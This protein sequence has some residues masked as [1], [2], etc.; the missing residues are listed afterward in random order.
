M[1][2]N[3]VFI[4]LLS[5]FSFFVYAEK[6]K[7]G[8]TKNQQSVELYFFWSHRCPHCLEA[9]PFIENLA[10]HYS[11]L[12]LQSHD[13]IDNQPSINLYINMAAKLDR[14]PNA[15]PAFIFC[16]QM[17][18]GFD[19]KLTTGQEL[20]RKLLA[21][22]QQTQTKNT[23]REEAFEIPLIGKIHYQDFSLP[24]FTLIIAALDA[25]NPCAFFVLFFLLSL[26]VHTRERL[27][28]AMIG[29]TF[30]CVSGLMYFIFMAAWLNLFLLTEELSIITAIAGL[31]AIIVGLIN[32]K[33][34]FFFKRGISLS[35]SDAAKPKLFQ[36]MRNLIQT[37][38]WSGMLVATAVLAI[39][40]NSYELLC[41]AGLP[42]VYTRVLTLN[43]LSTNE[44]YL[45]LAFYNFI[46][47]V[48]L[49][50]IVAIFTMTLG[51][52][53]I[54][55]KEGRLLK[56]LSG[57]MMLGLGGLLFFAPDL[58]N[59][60]FASIAVIGIAILITLVFALLE[61]KLKNRTR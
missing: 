19:S 42:M 10:S 11:W 51:S 14:N 47:I 60:M 27:R 9:K 59:N 2:K 28:I 18:Q 48:P 43:Q 45:Y 54:S 57:G 17:I 52:K 20:E 36:K 46:Y 31:V 25:F 33:D 40:A 3:V 44:Y 7:D 12:N 35:L 5:F 34:Y 1:L 4:L 13:L 30:V 50:I 22:H 6:Q 29:G 37:A 53:K 32:I 24:V 61:H 26:I 56:L 38:K 16:Q 8:T 58:L 41:T 15:V 49:L 23:K 55:E 21:C 39:V